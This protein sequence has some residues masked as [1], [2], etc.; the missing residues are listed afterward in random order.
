[1]K[2]KALFGLSVFCLCA[3][4]ITAPAAASTVAV[5]FSPPGGVH[6]VG[7]IF[8][9]DWLADIPDLVV[10]WGLDLSFNA[11][12]LSLD[13][14]SIGPAWFPILGPEPDDYGGLAFPTSVSGANVLLATLSFRALAPG[15]TAI[16]ASFDPLNFAEGFPLETGQFA[17]VQLT[18][19]AVT[20]SGV[21]E[22]ALALP[23]ALILVG[24]FAWRESRRRGL[25]GFCR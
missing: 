17:D 22:P 19:G 4:T 23:L 16:T 2:L 21:P 25:T 11:T 14:V 6:G 9:I 20:V 3:V 5:S 12:V 8:T 7:D 13:G 24:L 10:G 18:G 1:M 15:S